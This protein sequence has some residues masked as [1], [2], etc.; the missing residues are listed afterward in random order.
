MQA[1]I[2]NHPHGA[3]GVIGRHWH[4]SATFHPLN[5]HVNTEITLG[6]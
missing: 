6:K 2:M 3:M 1:K 4:P 5:N